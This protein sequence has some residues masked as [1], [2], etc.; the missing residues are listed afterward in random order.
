M[1][2]WRGYGFRAIWSDK[3]Y[4]F[5]AIWSGV[6]SSN[7]L[8]KTE[9]KNNWAFLV[10][11]RV[12]KFVKSGLVKGRT[13]TNQAAHPRP[14]YMG[15]TPPGGYAWYF[16]SWFIDLMSVVLFS[17]PG[18]FCQRSHPNTRSL[19][20]GVNPCRLQV[21][22][23]QRFVPRS[24]VFAFSPPN[25]EQ[26]WVECDSRSLHGL[27]EGAAQGLRF[28]SELHDFWTAKEVP[29]DCTKQV[30]AQGVSRGC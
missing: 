12:A 8:Q 16:N 15:V 30:L 24:C 5:Q 1:C 20:I 26:Q 28:A 10:W 19:H 21:L 14:N 7:R 4:G 17:Y 13:F 3:G 29:D 6:A 9:N 2:R 23:I 25:E 11:Y 22:G 27:H 18:G